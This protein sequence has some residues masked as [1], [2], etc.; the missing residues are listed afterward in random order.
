MGI[1]LGNDHLLWVK[2]GAAAAVP[3]LGQGDLSIK[4]G[5]KSIDTSSKTSG[6]WDTSAGGNRTGSATLKLNPE[7]PDAGYTAFETV[8][9]SAPPQN[10]GIE[11]RKG[12]LDGTEDDTVFACTVWCGDFNDDYPKDGVV[13]LDTTFNFAGA[14]TVDTL[15]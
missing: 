5:A 6:G 14:P 15:K 13:S 10:F 1:R 2:I 4:R 9:K 12:G 7:L 8:G 3:V 11:V